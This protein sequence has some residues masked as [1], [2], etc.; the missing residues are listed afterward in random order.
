M[1]H[2]QGT[3]G[4]GTSF[5]Y[6]TDNSIVT[7]IIRFV[8]IPRQLWSIFIPRIPRRGTASQVQLNTSHCLATF[9][10]RSAGWGV[11]NFVYL[12][13]FKC[14]IYL[15]PPPSL[16]ARGDRI[17]GVRGTRCYPISDSITSCVSRVPAGESARWHSWVFDS[18]VHCCH[19]KCAT[20][21][22][23]VPHHPPGN[24]TSYSHSIRSSSER[25]KANYL[26]TC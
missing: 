25:S 19:K 12:L 15:D 9:P 3:N 10:Y 17:F 18:R 6:R 7:G 21:L 2:V 14:L 4:F 23:W 5:S 13:F 16:T 1:C 11:T 22:T 26:T 20:Y 8:L 24:Y